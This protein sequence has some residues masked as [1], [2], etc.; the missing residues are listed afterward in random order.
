MQSA[1][2]FKD[3]RL[4][5]L[6]NLLNIITLLQKSHFVRLHLQPHFF[7]FV[8]DFLPTYLFHR[9]NVMQL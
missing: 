3:F 7:R 9:F 2:M 8:S 6:Q 1:Y 4:T 5:E